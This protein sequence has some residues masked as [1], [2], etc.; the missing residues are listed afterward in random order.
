MF[1]E[2]KQNPNAVALNSVT[3]TNGQDYS[4]V[5]ITYAELAQLV[6]RRREMLARLEAALPA[7]QRCVLLV[8]MHAT[9]DSVI[10]YLAA[11][12][13]RCV[14]IIIDPEMTES[15]HQQLAKQ[16]Q[17]HAILDAG[18]LCEN[19]QQQF[20]ID[21]DVAILLPT[22]GSTGGAKYVALSY[23]NLQANA[24]SICAYL[25]IASGDCAMNTLPL[26]YSYG[27][28]VLNTHLLSG[29]SL[30]LTP[31]TIVDKAFWQLMKTAGV[32]SFAGVPHFYEML[33]R[34][35]FTRMTLPHLKYFT[36]AGGKLAADTLTALCEFSRSS[37]KRF[38]I[39][40]GQTEATA[41]MAYYEVE[42]DDV[43]PGIIGR[44]IVNGQFRLKDGELQYAGPNVM[45]GYVHDA[46]DFANFEP[47]EWLAT[48][49]LAEVDAQR[50]YY[51]VGRKK[52]FIK[53]FGI[54]I[55]LD[56]LENNIRARGVECYCSGTDK[57]LIV[58]TETLSHEQKEDL[59][60]YLQ[61]ETR[62]HFSAVQLIQ[63]PSLPLTA[64]GKR[65][66]SAIDQLAAQAVTR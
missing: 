7:Q 20:S 46:E 36:Q 54:R 48:G 28:S 27:L 17:A 49:D 38:F 6:A 65:D 13:Q 2:L 34:L 10:D 62:I 19:G 26:F 43:T 47:I 64:N 52:R 21:S 50:N 32:T 18:K 29:A 33:I 4:E 16:F 12:Q 25:P 58:A 1:F 15:S 61:S 31:Y 9:L 23:A 60:Q 8:K 59:Q 14:A 39:M 66:Y 44:A 51:I 55:D 63:L 22:S 11:L 24:E 35:R 37:N 30:L 56:L 41:R 40:Y 53:P 42:Q 3:S 57:R 5:A 45:M